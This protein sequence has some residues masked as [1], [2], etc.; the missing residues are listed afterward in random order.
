MQNAGNALMNLLAFSRDVTFVLNATKFVFVWG[1][2]FTVN[3]EAMHGL[4]FLRNRVNIRLWQIQ[5][6]LRGTNIHGQRSSSQLNMNAVQNKKCASTYN[7]INLTTDFVK[8]N[9]IKILLHA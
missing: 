6:A 5:E 1:T 3:Q 2:E 4:T 8:S 7:L 9:L